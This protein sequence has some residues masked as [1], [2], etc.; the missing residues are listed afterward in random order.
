[1]GIAMSH[2]E[3]LY[4][5]LIVVAFLAFAGSLAVVSEIESRRHAKAA[6]SEGRE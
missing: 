5:A 6:D 4:L 1:L 2:V 3:T